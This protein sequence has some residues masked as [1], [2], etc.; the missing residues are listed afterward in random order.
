MTAPLS[1]E[2]LMRRVCLV[3]LAIAATMWLAACG[4]TPSRGSSSSSGSFSGTSTIT[5][6]S[7]ASTA[8]LGD[9]AVQFTATGGSG[10][11]T[12]AVNGTAGGSATTGTIDSTG[13][14]TPPAVGATVLANPTTVTITA[15][16][17]G[18]TSAGVALSLQNP[19]AT[20]TGVAVT[21]GGTLLVG[22]PTGITVTG[23]N[24]VS[25]A[26]VVVGGSSVAATVAS[27]T[28]LT[29]T[30]TVTTAG[31]VV[32]S[33]KNPDPGSATSTTT[34]SLTA[35]NPVVI[36]G[37]AAKGLLN[38]ATVNV[39][40]VSPTT[41]ADVGAALGT[42]KTDANGVFSITLSSLPATGTPL[43]VEA[44]GGTYVDETNVYGTPI[45]NTI[46]VSTLIDDGSVSVSGLAITPVTDMISSATQSALGGSA[47]GVKLLATGA[48]SSTHSSM[49][50]LISGHWGITSDP[51]KTTPTSS[52]SSSSTDGFKVG[53]LSGAMLECAHKALAAAPTVDPG[54]FIKALGAD[55]ADGV[56]DGFGLVGGKR[57]PIIIPGTTPGIALSA[58]AGT[59]DFLS[60]L[61][62]YVTSPNTELTK[63]N[64]VPA[65]SPPTSSLTT[66]VSPVVTTISTAIVTSP[67]TPPSAGLGASSSGAI[68]QLSFSGHQYVFIAAHTSGVAVAD[69]TNPASPTAKSWPGLYTTT[70]KNQPVGGVILIPGTAAHAQAVVFAYASKHI[71]IVNAE[72][73]ATGTPPTDGSVPASGLID[74]EGDL[75]ITGSI[76][77]FSG[78]SA[79]IAGGIPVAG[80]GVWLATSDGYA[81]L[82]LRTTPPT[83]GTAVPVAT[84]QTLAE[85]L[86]GD[87]THG[88]LLTGNY[89]GVQLVDIAN[90]AA[91]TS[92]VV[93]FLSGL[94]TTGFLS[95]WNSD[96]D[97]DSVDTGLQIGILTYEDTNYAS[98]LNLG[99]GT[100]TVATAT[101]PATFALPATAGKTVTFGSSPY[102]I[103]SGSAVDSS[104]HL[105]LFMA[106][107]STSWGVGKV[108][109]PA[110]PAST[111]AGWQGLSDWIYG[112]VSTS[113]S[114]YYYATD[115]H[116]VGIVQNN[117]DGR[118]YGYLLAGTFKSV[119]QIDMTDIVD[120][121]KMPRAG[122][123]GDAA[124]TPASDPKTAGFMS[125]ITWP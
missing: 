122:T 113:F 97:A 77:G 102:P 28:S 117:T 59:T 24:F 121:T 45:A 63:D 29:A 86:G 42:T 32:F 92:Y 51:E 47:S 124:H 106:G 66:T 83:L 100:K 43:R 70:F 10:S 11:Y 87:V 18:V 80:A 107:Y 2:M 116:A 111:T 46:T 109:D 41:G 62:T 65:G 67:A 94:P 72:T 108:D 38:G 123:T 20:V 119:I 68:S 93:D 56:F 82:D 90:I 104:S 89:Y 37:T 115:P 21:G 25:G 112:D 101:A 26:Q 54:N 60:C 9:P 99:A 84:G 58:Y 85:N 34:A 33:V 40:A 16:A 30:V 64:G 98:F 5:V 71:A 105:A 61:Q 73:L 103:F 96:I 6:T 52:A 120:P 79:Y 57:T 55:I 48:T 12:W 44:S 13:K 22:V 75:P 53:L 15:S 49:K 35:S 78:G 114:G 110:H 14:Y 88:L 8:R 4:F 19:I 27:A 76:V 50:T 1:M 95:S 3:L 31:S 36:A 125:Q 7:A 81:F 39:F 91:P 118:T 74:Y 23:T 69:V 17:G